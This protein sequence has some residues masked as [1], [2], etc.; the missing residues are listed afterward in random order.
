MI[1]ER[2]RRRRREDFSGVRF[3]QWYRKQR[4]VLASEH[5]SYDGALYREIEWDKIDAGIWYVKLR[6]RTGNMKPK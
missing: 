3:S 1:N 4:L 2:A 6:Y 5:G